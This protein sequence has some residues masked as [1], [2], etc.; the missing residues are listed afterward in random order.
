MDVILDVYVDSKIDIT[1]GFT[2]RLKKHPYLGLLVAK[3]A[4]SMVCQAKA[5][6]MSCTF[7]WDLIYPKSCN[8]RRLP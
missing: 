5:K 4:I 8:G 6:D 7:F 1:F 3:E 2:F